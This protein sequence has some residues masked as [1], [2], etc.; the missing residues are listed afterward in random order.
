M[1]VYRNAICEVIWFYEKYSFSKNYF[2]TIEG[3][4]V[5]YINLNC[6]SLCSCFLCS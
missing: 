4:K 2:Y 5:Q 6:R 3:G 1:I